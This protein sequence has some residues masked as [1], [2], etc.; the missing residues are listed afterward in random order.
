M[1]RPSWE[2]PH[3]MAYSYPELHEP[4]LHDKAM[5]HEGDYLILNQISPLYLTPKVGTK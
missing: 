5:I 3:G 4:L 2:A 1:T